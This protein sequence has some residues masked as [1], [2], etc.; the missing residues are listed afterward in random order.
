MI[1]GSPEMPSAGWAMEASEESGLPDTER[2]L[3]SGGTLGLMRNTAA[4]T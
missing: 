3:G 1:N 4:L 2:G